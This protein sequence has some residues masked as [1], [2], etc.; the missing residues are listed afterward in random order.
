MAGEAGLGE[1]GADP[2]EGGDDPRC[3]ARESPERLRPDG[4]RPGRR[5]LEAGASYR[6]I[7][8]VTA[9][10]VDST[11][12]HVR[13]PGFAQDQHAAHVLRGTANGS[14]RPSSGSRPDSPANELCS[15]R[16]TRAR[17]ARGTL[18]R[19][20]GVAGRR[21]PRRRCS[22]SRGAD[23]RARSSPRPAGAHSGSSTSARYPLRWAP[24]RSRHTPRSRRPRSLRAGPSMARAHSLGCDRGRGC[25][26]ARGRLIRAPA[27]ATRDA[28]GCR[29]TETRPRSVVRHAGHGA[30]LPRARSAD[31][32]AT[33]RLARVD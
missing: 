6:D 10:A 15:W 31:A 23:R 7:I 19:H 21:H 8:R 17:A 29:S 9:D 24:L 5:S 16:P 32:T 30:G 3:L 11:V 33:R 22:I 26:T 1:A 28:T 18:A 25:S 13:Q 12:A 27:P 4:G 20:L 14:I 2:V